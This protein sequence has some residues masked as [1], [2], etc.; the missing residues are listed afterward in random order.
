MVQLSFGLNLVMAMRE[1][2]MSVSQ[3]LSLST[4]SMSFRRD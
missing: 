2:R 1:C 4:A 3:A